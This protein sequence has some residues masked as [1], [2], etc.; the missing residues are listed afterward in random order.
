MP[1]NHGFEI[2]EHWRRKFCFIKM[3]SYRCC[4]LRNSTLESFLKIC[5]NEVYTLSLVNYSHM[6]Y[7]CHASHFPK[8]S[9]LHRSL[10]FSPDIPK[11]FIFDLR[12]AHYYYICIMDYKSL[13]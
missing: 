7:E 12:K 5:G 6:S 13:S 8:L 1:Y 9:S 3:Y 4:L 11:T 2:L 10:P